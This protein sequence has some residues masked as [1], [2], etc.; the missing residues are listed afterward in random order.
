MGLDAQPPLRVRETVG[1]RR[2]GVGCRD[3]ARW[4]I[5]RLEKERIEVEG[6]E[7]I[8]LGAP[9]GPIARMASLPYA[10]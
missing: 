9:D 7:A 5:Q 8:R 10:V 3:I 4:S 2:L 6:G 1:E